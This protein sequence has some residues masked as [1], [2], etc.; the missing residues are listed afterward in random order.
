MPRVE[1]C[2]ALPERVE[3]LALQL[4]PGSTAADAVHASGL[5]RDHAWLRSGEFGLGVFGTVVA[6]TRHLR[7]GDRLE[8]Y[9]LLP[10]D[11]KAQRRRRAAMRG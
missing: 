1:V 11:P 8:I 5:S 7:D 10:Q 2:L 6:P 3:R 9:R 4:P